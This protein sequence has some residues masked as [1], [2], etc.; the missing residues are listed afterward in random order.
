MGERVRCAGFSAASRSPS[1]LAARCLCSWSERG[2]QC[3]A[4][5]YSRIGPDCWSRWMG[6][7]SPRQQLTSRPVSPRTLERS[8]FCSAS[9]PY[10]QTSFATGAALVVM[11]THGRTGLRRSIMG[12]VAGQVLERGS[13]PLVLVRPGVPSA[14]G[15]PAE[16]ATVP[17]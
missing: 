3:G 6:R 5:R 4:S 2:S 16:L 13:A 10:P 8:W 14:D 12:S 7:G 15:A 9:S 11:A 17:A 1:W